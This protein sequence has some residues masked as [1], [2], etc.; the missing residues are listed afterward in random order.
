[1]KGIEYFHLP[2]AQNALKEINHRL[3]VAQSVVSLCA[4]VLDA[5]LPH[6]E[7][8]VAAALTHCVGD[9]LDAQ[10]TRIKTLLEGGAS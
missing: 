5:E 6:H 1:M 9:I 10:M 8:N 7:S 2:G 4:A 3:D